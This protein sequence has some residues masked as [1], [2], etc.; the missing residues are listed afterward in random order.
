MN[1]LKNLIIITLISIPMA[2]FAAPKLWERNMIKKQLEKAPLQF[3]ESA[4]S[5]MGHTAVEHKRY[6]LGENYP[7]QKY[8]VLTSN[9]DHYETFHNNHMGVH[10]K[11]EKLGENYLKT[12]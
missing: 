6:I 3:V 4:A 5:K 8:N 11:R 10:H 9:K 12:N 7:G 1:T 2:S